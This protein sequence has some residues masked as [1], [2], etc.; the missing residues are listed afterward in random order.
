[1]DPK[2]QD[3]KILNINN[4]NCIF[5]YKQSSR[6]F[7]NIYPQNFFLSSF[8]HNRFKFFNENSEY[9]TD[10]SSESE[11][12]ESVENVIEKKVEVIGVFEK[13]E[14]IVHMDDWIIIGDD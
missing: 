14:K 13:D 2:K 6:T 4:L 11:E 5:L 7:S 9:L 8:L 1:M 3:E 10:S 12:E